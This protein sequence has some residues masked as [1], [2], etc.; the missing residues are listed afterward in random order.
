M[1][2][3]ERRSKPRKIEPKDDED[4]EPKGHGLVLAAYLVGG[5]G[6]LEIMLVIA[7]F[8]AQGADKLDKTFLYVVLGTAFVSA[9]L[10]TW[11]KLSARKQ[12]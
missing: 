8:L 12:G 4:M 2:E 5:I 11:G 3:T 7:T 6:I 10:F 9:V 1:A